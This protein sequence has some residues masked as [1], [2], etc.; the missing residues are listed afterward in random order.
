ML[1]HLLT[2][3]LTLS[4][5]NGEADK[6]DPSRQGKAGQE[7]L[8]PE[9]RQQVEK[10][11]AD[12]AAERTN[13]DS[14]TERN[15]ILWRWINAWG[16]SGRYVPVNATLYVLGN[17]IMPQGLKMTG[18]QSH[19]MLDQTVREFSLLEEDP[20]AIG[21]TTI[22][23]KGPFIAGSSV[24]I[25][26][27]YTVG[28]RG[29][30]TGGGI[31]LGFQ[32]SSDIGRFQTT[33]PAAPNYVSISSSNPQARFVAT[34]KPFGG[35][36]GGFY[37]IADVV[38]FEL[39]SGTLQK[40]DKLTITYGDRSGGS[41]GLVMQTHSNDGV[42]L[43]LY[44]DI[45][46]EE[47]P[48]LMG[49]R[50]FFSLPPE[51]VSVIG[52]EVAGVHGFAPSIV[53]R[54]EWFEISVRAEDQH[55]NRASGN[56]PAFELLL[57]GQ[58]LRKIPAG[59]EAITV[60]KDIKLDSAGSYHFSLRSEDGRIVGSVNPILVEE[61]PA[62]RIYW[63]ETHGHSG[64]AEG[65][66]SPE[67]YYRF[68]RDD[69][70]L[71]YVTHSEHDLWMD[72]SEWEHMRRNAKE[73]YEEGKFI[74]FLGWEW[75]ALR[76]WGGHHNVLF[77]TP[78]GR[79]R[80]PWQEAPVLSLLY[81]GL[82][83]QND[84]K[85]VLI[86]PHAHEPGDWR[87]NDPDMETLVEI[88]SEHGTFEWFGQYYAKSADIGFVAASDNHMGHPGYS[89]PRAFGGLQQAGGLG[90]VLAPGKTGN[91]I[92]EA[93]KARATYADTGK[94]IILLTTVNGAQPGNR[95]K[96]SPMRNIEG[97][98]VGAGEIKSVSIMRN[99]EEI[100]SQDYA[101]APQG[102]SERYLVELETS[103]EPLN[104]Q[105]EQP[106]GWR[107]WTG[108]LVV[109]GARVV[110]VSLIGFENPR[111]GFAR[112]SA[113]EPNTV[114]FSTLT[115]GNRSA[116]A[117]KLAEVT[118]ALSVSVTV[119]AAAEEG[120]S[121]SPGT[122]ASVGKTPAET[123]MLDARAMKDGLVETTLASGTYYN[124]PVR[125]RRVKNEIPRDVSFSFT[126]ANRMVPGDYYYIRVE[127]LDGAKA[128]S[129][130]IWIGGTPPR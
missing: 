45:A 43:P 37:G 71:D 3:T 130:P 23:D 8:A 84:T 65:Q 96:F 16:M 13:A 91:A 87:R 85:D 95:R 5:C 79:S 33:D 60:L 36:H 12:V 61:K 129:S 110:D 89:S 69:A 31:L 122:S 105:R 20:D 21:G 74:T 47:R 75:T 17:V 30:K 116:V 6:T 15:Q 121:P 108:K 109:S 102:S 117:L 94:R 78:D 2:V 66:G 26:Q 90:A 55:T 125:L 101:T 48:E 52:G 107:P 57:N 56:M 67:G 97:R 22:I 70:R 98:A 112:M 76:Q 62:T 77:R 38:V 99:G 19:D 40:G 25:R 53:E 41:P 86:I 58:T 111:R 18:I 9:L 104:G 106:R 46:G 83:A 54:E 93:L 128:W 80:V 39:E 120:Y 63:G 28:T 24:T 81:Q 119:D 118:S 14:V 35:M 72:D 126:D 68:A 103:S 92:F 113:D 44:V 64:F 88:M 27:V 100:W 51:G 7:Y 114:E 11:K 73:F 123:V 59:T 42:L 82:R 1:A 50:Q 32:W 10:L 124:D 49:R 29:I 115:R 4:A 127:Q 34:S